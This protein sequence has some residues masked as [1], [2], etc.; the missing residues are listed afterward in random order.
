MDAVN[1]EYYKGHPSGVECIKIARHFNFCLG[2]ALKYIWRAGHKSYD[3]REDLRKAIRYLEEEIERWET[4]NLN[5][6]P[7]EASSPYLG[8]LIQ[9]PEHSER[10]IVSPLQKRVESVIA[11]E[12]R[13]GR[14]DGPLR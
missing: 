5:Q 11:Q 7:L 4:E 8:P 13:E 2:A 1:P 3:P 12:R 6:V 10:E 9:T 14:R